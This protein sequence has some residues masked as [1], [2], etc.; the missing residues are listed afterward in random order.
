MMRIGAFF[1]NPSS[2]LVDGTKLKR[3]DGEDY[4]RF[5]MCH[6]S[7]FRGI[8]GLDKIREIVGFGSLG[9]TVSYGPQ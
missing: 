3:Q 4:I 6:L 2:I 9:P 7:R 8:Q 1:L 5:V